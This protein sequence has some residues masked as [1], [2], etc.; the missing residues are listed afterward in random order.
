[1]STRTDNAASAEYAESLY[2]QISA[3][4]RSRTVFEIT[5]SLLATFR[6]SVVELCT[7][8]IDLTTSDRFSVRRQR[9][10]FPQGR[11]V[12]IG[13][14]TWIQPFKKSCSN[15]TVGVGPKQIYADLEDIKGVFKYFRIPALH[16][17]LHFLWLRKL[18]GCLV[19]KA[20]T[21]RKFKDK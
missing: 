8:L 19:F 10:Y 16:Y 15:D 20:K 13:C 14:S 17:V 4:S 9:D 12:K 1:M 21:N 5:G 11:D 6:S 7:F 3:Y 2:C 18:C